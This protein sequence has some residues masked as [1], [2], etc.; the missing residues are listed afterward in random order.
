MRA[1]DSLRTDAFF[2][3]NHIAESDYKHLQD[4]NSQGIYQK[5]FFNKLDLIGFFI[6]DCLFSDW[7]WLIRDR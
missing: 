6:S 2:F 7:K 3:W 1:N 4:R 5:F